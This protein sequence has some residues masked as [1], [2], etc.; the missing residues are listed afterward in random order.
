MEKKKNNL[1]IETPWGKAV[2]AAGMETIARGFSQDL[3]KIRR[4]IAQINSELKDGRDSKSLEKLQPALDS[5]T[6]KIENLEKETLT[7]IEALEKSQEK[8]TAEMREFM[9][10][11]RKTL[12][13]FKEK[14]EI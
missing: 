6:K 4:S 13:L 10:L 9:D 14:L 5:L 1:T 2:S 12:R 11:T 8:S 7:R 3:E